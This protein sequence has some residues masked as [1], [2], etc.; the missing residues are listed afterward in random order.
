M[1]RFDINLDDDITRLLTV[2][3]DTLHVALGSAATAETNHVGGNGGTDIAVVD[4]ITLDL[5]AHD[6]SG[7]NGEITFTD[8]PSGDALVLTDFSSISFA[9]G[10]LSAAPAA[11]EYLQSGSVEHS[12][13]GGPLTIGDS[14]TVLRWDGTAL[15]HDSG[16][17]MVAAV[18]G[19]AVSGGDVVTLTGVG[20][21]TVSSTSTTLAPFAGFVSAIPLGQ[22]VSESFTITFS[23]GTSAFTETF[24]VHF[25]G[26][27][28]SGANLVIGGA[29][30]QAIDLGPGNDTLW[31]GPD[32]DGGDTVAGGDGNDII[33]GR[34]EGDFL[35]GD[36]VNGFF[37]DDTVELPDGTVASGADTLYGG[38]G[39]DILLGGGW[40]DTAVFKDGTFQDGEEVI[41][42]T[43]GNEIW[44]GA[45]D[46]WIHGANGADTL[47]GGDGN[48]DITGH[49]G[50]DVIYT[51]N[52]SG[53]DA[54]S[55]NPA[56]WGDVASGG[57]GNDTIYGGAF[58]DE[59]RDRLFG[60]GG[61]DEIYGGGGDDFIDG[62]TGADTL[63]GGAGNDTLTGGTGA[64]VF[65]F[66]TGS[67]ED[68]VT[69]FS[70]STDRLDV[71]AHFSSFAEVQLAMSEVQSGGTTYTEIILSDD[72]KIVLRNINMADLT[73]D[74]FIF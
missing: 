30:S 60:E 64:D 22:T 14:S 25:A 2:G 18:N 46:D 65:S 17:W 12:F 38:E 71:S 62:G 45:G 29:G 20:A 31:A 1:A 42:E 57:D 55:G 52:G 73:A 54:A 32:D 5:A 63:Y 44:A 74:D 51:G 70:L 26:S 50:D 28:N 35:I 49:G 11:A 61:N 68:L 53:N 23:D 66:G 39:D 3:D 37:A 56:D 4:G 40:D 36:G 6:L 21:I 16:L 15:D 41:D 7:S 33:G 59:D 67:G 13:A 47:G 58:G 34:A 24:T 72:D 27:D 10:S 69:D 19:T 9:N 43:A 8:A 48:D